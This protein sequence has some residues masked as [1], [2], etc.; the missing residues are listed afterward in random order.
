MTTKA[1]DTQ[2]ATYPPNVGQPN[3]LGTYTIDDCTR[4]IW[5]QRIDG[6]VRVTDHPADGQT[7]RRYVVERGLEQD[8]YDA[9]KALVED[10]IAQAAKHCC[11]PVISTPIDR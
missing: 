10:Y 8:G 3:R 5:G 1:V 9:L 7:G 4:V 6:V 11:I 2:T